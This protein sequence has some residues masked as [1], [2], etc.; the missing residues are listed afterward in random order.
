MVP[1]VIIDLALQLFMEEA[2]DPNSKVHKMIM[3]KVG[4][5]AG[6]LVTRALDGSMGQEP[7]ALENK[8]G[9][10]TSQSGKGTSQSGKGT[11]QSGMLDDASGNPHG[12]SEDEMQAEIARYKRTP[13]QVAS[14]LAFPVV[15][16]VVKGGTDI[17]K[18]Y[19]SLLGNALMAVSNG[20]GSDG[21]SNPFAMAPALAMGQQAKGLAYGIAGDTLNDIARDISTDIKNNREK[22]RDAELLIRERPNGQFYESRR[23]LT[24]DGK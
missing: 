2:T 18:G 8:S 10:G 1:Q 15:G 9:K 22:E 3:D 14:D 6:N 11:S 21:F 13:L 19:H 12:R 17:K 5:V 23:H 20:M 4:N 16:K 7:Q 24:K